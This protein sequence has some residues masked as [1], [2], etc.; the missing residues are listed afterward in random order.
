M[1][2][3]KVSEH[4]KGIPHDH[5]FAVATD[6]T[7]MAALFYVSDYGVEL[8]REKAQAEAEFLDKRQAKWYSFDTGSR[9]SVLSKDSPNV[10]SCFLYGLFGNDTYDEAKRRAEKLCK[11]LNERDAGK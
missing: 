11:E 1:K 2:I 4:C 8:A 3:F 7:G 5:H 9:F 6:S 10:H